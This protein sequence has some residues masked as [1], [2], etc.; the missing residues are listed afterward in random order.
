MKLIT[1]DKLISSKAQQTKMFGVIIIIALIM[2]IL[3]RYHQTNLRHVTSTYFATN[4]HLVPTDAP[5]FDP[6]KDWMIFFH[7]QKTSGS[8]WDLNYM[9][10]SL[11]VREKRTEGAWH[12]A[13]YEQYGI[14]VIDENTGRIVR[15][16]GDFCRRPANSSESWYL[17]SH[18][19]DFEW[20]CGLVSLFMTISKCLSYFKH[21]Y[22][23][24]S[25][26]Q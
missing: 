22:F 19:K 21:A 18:E 23:L 24:A 16:K 2:I 14:P 6:N 10:G 26:S 11:M 4:R 15:H 7:I 3:I 5:S 20:S 1:R 25:V 17:S 13:C 12:D 8:S 9:I